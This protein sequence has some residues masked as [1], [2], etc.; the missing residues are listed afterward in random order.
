MPSGIEAAETAGA[1]EAYRDAV[2]EPDA[3]R[4]HQHRQ[5]SGPARR[6]RGG[7]PD[8]AQVARSAPAASGAAHASVANGFEA[9]PGAQVDRTLMERDPHAIVEGVAI[10]AWAVRA[11]ER[12]H[13]RAR[14][15]E[16]GRRARCARPSRQRRRGLHRRDAPAA[17]GR[18]LQVEVRELVGL[19]SWSARR[20]CCCAPSSSAAPSP[21]SAR[22][23]P[24]RRACGVEP[25]LVNNVKTLAA[26]PWIV[27]TALAPMPRWA[28]GGAGHDAAPARRGRAQAGHRRGAHGHD[29]PRGA[30]RSRWL[31]A[32]ARSRPCSW[33]VRPAASCPPTRWT[34]RSTPAR[35]RRRGARGIGHPAGH[36]R[37]GV[38]RRPGRAHEPL[39]SP[40]RPAARPSPAASGRA[41]SR[42]WPAVLQ[43]PCAARR[44]GAGGRPGRGHAR[45]RALRAGGRGVN[46][47]RSRGCDTSRRSSRPTS[48]K[49]AAQPASASPSRGGATGERSE[50]LHATDPAPPQSPSTR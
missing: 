3:R 24:S 16:H 6:R 46:P 44:R 25:T 17:P 47:L 2:R 13:R 37:I 50:T 40:T 26:V 28:P 49:V 23:I 12:H 36:R 42:S 19:A 48:S 33:V 35:S 41:V 7:L 38:P 30:R 39:S 4:G 18:P 43:R 29:H 27:A 8:R 5:R 20:P 15:C 10:A 1:W 31:R 32:R 21:T 14:L 11:R 45:C 9:D 22:R 34:R